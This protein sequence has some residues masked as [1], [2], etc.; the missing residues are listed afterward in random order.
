MNW[1]RVL[2]AFAIIVPLILGLIELESALGYGSVAEA[3]R[4]RTVL[5]PIDQPDATLDER[6]VESKRFPNGE[7][8]VGI[9]QSSHNSWAI[10]RGG[11]TLVVKDSRGQVR[12]FFGHICGPAGFQWTVQTATN[13]DEFYSRTSHLLTEYFWR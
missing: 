13:L 7:W 8:I 3:H 9:G 2:I 11:G 5:E 4:L 1:R 12:A 6:D 10:L